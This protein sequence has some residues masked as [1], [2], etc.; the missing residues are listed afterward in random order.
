[1]RKNKQ[2]L[3]GGFGGRCR[4]CKNQFVGPGDRCQRCRRELVERNRRKPR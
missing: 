1:M 3:F 4:A 2:N